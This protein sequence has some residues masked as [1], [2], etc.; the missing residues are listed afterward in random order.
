MVFRLGESGFQALFS[1]KILFPYSLLAASWTDS[2]MD[3]PIMFVILQF[4]VYAVVLTIGVVR[5]KLRQTSGLLG[6]VH[7][8]AVAV[9]V[10][11]V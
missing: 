2:F 11:A 4:P 3:F 7:L 8:V 6:I 1:A 5:E 10:W 9:C